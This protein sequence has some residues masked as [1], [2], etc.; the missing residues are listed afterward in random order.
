MGAW[1]TGSF[2]NDDASDWVYTLTADKTLAP[3]TSALALAAGMS[4][5]EAPA[6]CEALA[7]AEVL[8]AYQGKPSSALP[9]EVAE[10]LMATK[11][12][13]GPNDLALARTVVQRVLTDSELQ[14][15]WEDSDEFD[16]W[17][18]G[19]EQLATRLQ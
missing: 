19:V 17:K 3:A 14:E 4:Y 1:G 10:W 12:A 16:S 2:E 6:A 18:A 11:P 13:I 15:L 7:A 9:P 8:A 5:L